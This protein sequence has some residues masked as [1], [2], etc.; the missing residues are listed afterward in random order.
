MTSKTRETTLQRGMHRLLPL[1]AA[2]GLA[3]P[4]TAL[5]D[6]T[7]L[8]TAPLKPD[9]PYVFVVHDSRSVK[10]QRVIEQSFR[11]GMDIRGTLY[12]TVANC[13]PFCL[14]PLKLDL[15]VETVAE[16]EIVDFMLTTLR[17]N[18]GTL[19]DVRAPRQFAYNTIPGSIN[20]FVQDLI[21]AQDDNAMPAVFERLGAKRREAPGWFRQQLEDYGLAGNGLQSGEWDF[22]EAKELIV[23]GI[24]PTSGVPA[25]V[26]DILLAAGYPASKLKWYR[27]GMAAWQYW[28]FTTVG[29][30][31]R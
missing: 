27:G 7:S 16:T 26:I 30:P 19:V 13:P 23:W 20:L 11:V 18:A 28:G 17:D 9:V 15:P 8:G 10:V 25:Q 14:Q 31:K 2:I 6:A 4:Q 21:K 22:T 29:T 12:Q 5:A 24:A 3:T 1:A